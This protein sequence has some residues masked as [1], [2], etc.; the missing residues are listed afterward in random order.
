MAGNAMPTPPAALQLEGARNEAAL[1]SATFKFQS[2]C[3]Q[4]E[5]ERSSNQSK[6]DAETAVP[7]LTKS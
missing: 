5:D 7:P 2:E 4:P 3:E 1:N 6:P